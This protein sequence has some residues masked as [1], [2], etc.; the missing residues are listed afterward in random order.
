MINESQYYEEKSMKTFI[1][2]CHPSEHSF[3]S[4]VRDSFIKGIVD[5]GNEYII[6]DL[7]KMDS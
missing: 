1:V 3:T 5:S 4:H 2:N 7:Y 6:S